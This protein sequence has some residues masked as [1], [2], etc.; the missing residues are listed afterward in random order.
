[1]P[2]SRCPGLSRPPKKDAARPVSV[3][4]LFGAM[5]ISSAEAV[6][7]EIYLAN[8]WGDAE[9]VS[10]PGSSFDRTRKLRAQL[11]SLIQESRGPIP[12]GRGMRRFQLDEVGGVGRGALHRGGPCH[13][14]G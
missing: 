3:I 2:V 14:A 5:P 9:S 1:M 6:F 4:F 11:S 8:A 10:G 7:T 13:P 12:S